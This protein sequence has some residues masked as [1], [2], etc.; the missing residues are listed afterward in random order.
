VAQLVMNGTSRAAYRSI[1]QPPRSTSV[2]A[3]NASKPPGRGRPRELPR[4]PPPAV[5]G[6]HPHTTGRRHRQV[7]PVSAELAQIG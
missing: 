4:G 3:Q 5:A 7:D 2:C 6:Q 1:S